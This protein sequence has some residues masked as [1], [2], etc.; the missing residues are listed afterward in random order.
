MV[1]VMVLCTAEACCMAV[2]QLGRRCCPPVMLATGALRCCLLVILVA[3]DLA[4]PVH[5]FIHLVH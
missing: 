2:L 4:Q 1:L 5:S 3:C